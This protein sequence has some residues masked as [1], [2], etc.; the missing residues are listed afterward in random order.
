MLG[1][2]GDMVPDTDDGALR[3]PAWQPPPHLVMTGGPATST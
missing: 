2:Y 1:V 3:S